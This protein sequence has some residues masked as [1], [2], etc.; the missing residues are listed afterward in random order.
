VSSIITATFTTA[1]PTT[2]LGVFVGELIDPIGGGVLGGTIGSE[3][4][5]GVTASY[6][7]STGSSYVGVTANYTPVPEGGN[8]ASVNASI[9]PP[10]Q[11]PNS[12][13]NG[14]TV[15]TTIQPTP[16]TGV[17]VT[18]SPGSG[19]PVAGPSVGTRVPVSYGASFDVNVTRFVKSAINSISN[20]F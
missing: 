20:W 1:A 2:A 15:S 3:V 11:N 5:V 9:V 13:A 16:F 10:T 14:P 18:K 12:I 8:G 6:V 4:G 7:P 17:T 19:P